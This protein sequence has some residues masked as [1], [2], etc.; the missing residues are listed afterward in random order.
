VPEGITGKNLEIWKSGNLEIWK[1][2][3]RKILKK[4]E[5][6]ARNTGPRFAELS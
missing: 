3:N 1:S 2:G 6:P 4:T 5:G